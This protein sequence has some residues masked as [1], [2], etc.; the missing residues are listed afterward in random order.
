MHPQWIKVSR[1]RPCERTKIDTYL[2]KQFNTFERGVDS[3][4]STVHWN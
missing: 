4:I 1:I 2:L 3:C